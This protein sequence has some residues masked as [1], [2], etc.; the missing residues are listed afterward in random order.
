MA[1]YR[2]FITSLSCALLTENFV[3]AGISAD[4]HTFDF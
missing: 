3:R 2:F 4:E 1:S